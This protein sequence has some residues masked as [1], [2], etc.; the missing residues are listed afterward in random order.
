MSK[1]D[2]KNDAAKYK[3]KIPSLEKGRGDPTQR[4]MGV[5]VIR[6]MKCRRRPTKCMSLA[7]KKLRNLAAK[8]RG[9]TAPLPSSKG[10]KEARSLLGPDGIKVDGRL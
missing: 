5:L 9:A 2:R 6:F 7:A 10:S 4:G 3:A 8:G 1:K